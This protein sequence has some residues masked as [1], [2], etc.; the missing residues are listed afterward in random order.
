M[1]DY[2]RIAD[3]VAADIAAGR[4][5]PGERLP[6]QRSF[7]RR[8]RIANSTA[9]RVYGELARRGLVTGEVGRGTFVRAPAAEPALADPGGAPVD[10]QLNFSVLPEQA[11]LLSAGLA[12]V[13]RPDVLADALRAGGVTGTAGARSAAAE[14]LARTGWWPEPERI[15]FTGNGKQALAAAIAALVPV[16]GRLGVEALTYPVVRTIAGRLGVSL[17]P[18]EMDEHGVLPGALR[19]S[20][21]RAVYLQPALHNPLGVTMPAARRAE[22]VAVLEELDVSVVEDGVYTFL[23]DEA[24]LAALAPDR[25]VFV[26]SL[27]KRIAPGL[28]LGFAVP[29][30]GWTDRIAAAVRG[31]GWTAPRFA[32]DVAAHHISDGTAA[33]IQ[34]AK[35]A[36]A[37]ARQAIAADRLTG[38]AVRADPRA[39]HCWWELPPPW[40]ADMFV[41]AAAREG[42]AVTP[43]AAF[44]VGTAPNAVRL[45]LASP[46]PERLSAALDVLA[47]IARGTP[48]LGA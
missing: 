10:L 1:E 32:V 42:I 13:L 36:D 12:A 26:D 27:S 17:V 41:A 44:A 18:L 20:G 4:L 31:G 14:L 9:A 23:S 37:A 47:G 40:R 21:L 11:A 5:R 2:R 34:Q 28:T 3:S 39:Y 16:G 48:E 22:V 38:F 19:A 24:P 15:L 29:P 35:R 43:A 7:A 46:P 45:A 33:V 30:A 25:T 8:H 6:A